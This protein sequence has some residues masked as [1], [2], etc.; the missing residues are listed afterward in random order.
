ME[1]K[2]LTATEGKLLKDLLF[3]NHKVY[4]VKLN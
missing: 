2:L 1:Q 3:F 4:I